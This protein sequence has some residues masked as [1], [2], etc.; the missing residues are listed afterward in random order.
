MGG[1]KMQI[2]VVPKNKLTDIVFDEK[3]IVIST[4]TDSDAARVNVP[5]NCVIRFN[6]HDIGKDDKG[7]AFTEEDAIAIKNFVR[8]NLDSKLIVCSCDAGVSRSP[9]MAAAIAYWLNGNDMDFWNNPKYIP[10]NHVYKT[11][12]NVLMCD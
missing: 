7:L 2:I 11:L 8:E 6:F 4:T 5:E 9:A 1:I 3:Y 10:N 12:L